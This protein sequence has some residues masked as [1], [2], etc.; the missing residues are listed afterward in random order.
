ME[1]SGQLTAVHLNSCEAVN[2]S[3]TLG[4]KKDN[5]CQLYGK[6]AAA[7]VCKESTNTK[8]KRQ[9]TAQWS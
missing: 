8:K 3:K 5:S 9:V 4:R 2:R 6:K 7:D 1:M